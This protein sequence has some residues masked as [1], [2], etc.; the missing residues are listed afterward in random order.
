MEGGGGSPA[1]E[2][3][4]MPL[5]AVLFDHDG[6]LVDSEP[7]HHRLWNG[8]LAAYGVAVAEADY[9]LRYAGLPCRANAEDLVR[10]FGL[11]VAPEALAEAK[12]AATRAFLARAAFPLMPGVPEAVEELDRLGLKL[13]VVTGANGHGVRRT[14]GAYGLA[15]RFAVVVTCDDVARSKPAPDC[16]LLAAR[17]LGLDPGDCVALEDTGHGLQAAH[18]AGMPCLALPTP[19]SRHH[20]FSQALAVLDG[21]PAAVAHLRRTLGAGD[22][23][24]IG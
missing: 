2:T 14:L 12:N 10:R 9:Q 4:A 6:T 5:R 13:G 15:G 20:D 3:S 17:K 24:G 1:L 19:M 23:P 11:A 18:G 21:L 8:V 16:Y 22:G 7:V